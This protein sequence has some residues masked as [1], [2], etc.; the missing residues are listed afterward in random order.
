MAAALDQSAVTLAQ[1]CGVQAGSF[2]DLAITDLVLDSRD[3]RA[4]AAFFALAGTRTHGLEHARDALARGAA[5]VLFDPQDVTQSVPEPCLAIVNLR[6]QLGEFARRFYGRRASPPVVTGITGTNGKTT[7]A[8]LLAQA[9]THAGT[10]AGYIGTLGYGILPRLGAH[11]LTTPDCLT[12]HRE[13][14]LMPVSNVALEV[15]SIG[16]EQDRLAGIDVTGAVFTNLGHDHLDVHNSLDAYARAK[17]LLFARPE[18]EHAVVN[19]DDPRAEVVCNAVSERVRI[20]SVSR[21]PGAG[22]DL[23]GAIERHDIN[24]LRIRLSG[25]YGSAVIES[26]LLGQFNAENLLLA[27]AALL[28][29]DVPLEDACSA[30]S[31]STAPPGRM[32]VFGGGAAPRVVVDYAHT[33][34][35][36]ARAL[37]AIASLSDGELWCVFGSGGDRDPSKRPAM[38]AAAGRAEHVVLTDDNPRTEDPAEIVA[39]IVAGLGEHPS[40]A[41]E[42]NRAAAIAYAVSRARAGDIVLVAGRGHER[43]QQRRDGAVALD[44]RE[45]VRR[46]LGE[47]T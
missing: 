43:V 10:T 22:A 13:I 27:L 23:C 33:P 31:V 21:N 8:W 39:G 46:L 24:G 34:D 19:I 14:A 20:L 25:S 17:A 1:V 45:C 9:L 35:A 16:L 7:V 6:A 11:R 2:A 26:S 29:L 4:G 5:I 30:L 40:V 44:D 37:A 41:V 42:H 28:N 12:L 3:V 36:L 32:E 47:R 15:S 38:G 18:L